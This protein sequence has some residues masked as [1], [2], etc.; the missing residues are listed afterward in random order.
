MRIVVRAAVA[1]AALLWVGPGWSAAQAQAQGS[2]NC[3]VLVD[4]SLSMDGYRMADGAPLLKT[5][6]NLRTLCRQT[7]EFGDKLRELHSSA[8]VRFSDQNTL[9]GDDLEQ[10]ASTAPDGSFVLMITDNVSDNGTPKTDPTEKFYDLLRNTDSVFSQITVLALRGSFS[11]PLYDPNVRHK[12]VPYR[13]PRALTLYVLGKHTEADSAGYRQLRDAVDNVLAASGY[14][15]FQAGSVDDDSAYVTFDVKPFAAEAFK[16]E[17]RS[18]KILA[19]S[20]GAEPTRGCAADSRFDDATHTFLILGQ[21]MNEDCEVRANLAVRFPARWCLVNA[22]LSASLAMRVDD[23]EVLKQSVQALP[24]SPS[25]ATLCADEKILTVGLKFDAFRFRDNVGFFDRLA[26]TFSGSFTA[27]GQLV[28]W[29][30]VHRDDVHLEKGLAEAWTYGSSSNISIT[31]SPDPA[32][33][34]K[35]FRLEEGVRA[36]IPQQQLDGYELVRY[37][38]KIEVRYDQSPLLLLLFGV[39]LLLVLLVALFLL[40]RRPTSYVIESDGGEETQIRIGL[41]GSAAALSDNGAM[42]LTLTNLAI[43]LLS[44]SNGRILRGRVLGTGGG[45]VEIAPPGMRPARR[46]GWSRPSRSRSDSDDFGAYEPNDIS[47]DGET[48]GTIAFN[49]RAVP[50]DAAT[51]GSGGGDDAF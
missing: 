50:R 5:I 45:R 32:I 9:I 23:P 25:R 31:S 19:E 28:V 49:V 46:V 11:G 37:P 12:R 3:D 20:D 17:S 36:V 29:G 7:Y 8:P 27:Q 14:H 15:R 24:V 22:G 51:G 10:W 39:I 35:V 30:S 4:V 43:A 6:E 38:V 33:Q 42:R 44:T 21:P 2:H 18:A 48:H 40:A 26:R 1:L 16:V 13:G 47:T 34:R 41:F